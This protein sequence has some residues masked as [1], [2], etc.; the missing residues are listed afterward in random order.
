MDRRNFFKAVG[1]GAVNAATT[2]SASFVSLNES[3]KPELDAIYS[4]LKKQ[5]GQTSKKVAG[6]LSV[7]GQRVDAASMQL[8]HQQMQLYIIFMLL[9]VSFVIDGGMSMLVLST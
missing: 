7:I 3:F 1:A 5:L 2:A 6:Q 8:A 9:V 4:D